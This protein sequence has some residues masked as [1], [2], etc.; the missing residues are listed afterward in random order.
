[1]KIYSVS[2]F[3]ELTA[4]FLSKIALDEYIEDV[5]RY[6]SYEIEEHIVDDTPYHS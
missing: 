4:I 5:L 2:M 1:V 3:G 6:D